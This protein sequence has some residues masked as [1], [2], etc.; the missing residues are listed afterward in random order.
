MNMSLK[1]LLS[2]LSASDYNEPAKIA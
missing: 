2:S 1:T